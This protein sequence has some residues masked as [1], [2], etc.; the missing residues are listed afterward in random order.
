[1]RCRV[2]PND[3]VERFGGDFWR[4]RIGRPKDG[5]LKVKGGGFCC[6]GKFIIG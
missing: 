1:M 3:S 4:L 5:D 2:K 6:S